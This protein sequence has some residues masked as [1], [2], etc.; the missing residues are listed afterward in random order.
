[1][2]LEDPAPMITS[3][4]TYARHSRA[5]GNDAVYAALPELAKEV[6]SAIEAG[7]EDPAHGIN[8]A[9]IL[10]DLHRDQE[11]LDWMRAHPVDYREYYQNLATAYAKIDPNNKEPIRANN[12]KARDCPRCPNAI[13]AYIDYHAL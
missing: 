9:A 8:F 7:D 10:L 2:G 12:L 13:L 4:D 3:A 6:W 5:W 1:M 11:A